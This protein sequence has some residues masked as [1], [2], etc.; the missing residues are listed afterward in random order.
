[1][2]IKA[3][4][5]HPA[6]VSG[7]LLDWDGVIAETKLDFTG[8][9]ERYYGGRPAML[10]EDAASLPEDERD[11]LM[12]DLRDLEV[13]GA[14]RAV[15]VQGA[16]ELLEWL[17][18]HHI[19]FCVVSRN[20]AESIEL[21]AKTIGVKLPEQVWNRDNSEFIKPDPRALKSAAASIGVAPRD[22]LF[23]GDFLYDLQGA[24]RAGMR[25]VLVQ[26]EEK[27]WDAW[28]DVS[29][30]KLA[31][32][33]SEL[34]DPKPL[35]PWEYREIHNK[36]GDKWLNGAWPISLTLPDSTSPTLDCWLARAAAFGVGTICV[37]DGAVI[38][39]ADWK[40]NPSFDLGMMGRSVLDAAREYLAPRYP[41]TKVVAGADGVKA[42]K[43]SLDLMRFI[44]RKIY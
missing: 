44:E 5:W 38:S 9:R 32:L 21:A 42:P 35:V 20:C 39:P 30:A 37:P 34:D 43:N 11:A 3:P 1:M 13:E 26:R 15:P 8:V 25:S 31:D 28:Y 18:S 7:F 23:I 2:D 36:R 6:C 40:A 17:G 16:P 14:K 12:R 19:P 27:G 22:C 29:Y 33:V 10:L 41:M 24:R 4:F